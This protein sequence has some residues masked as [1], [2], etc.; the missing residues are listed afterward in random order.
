MYLAV[1]LGI[2][3]QRH[4]P[5]ANITRQHLVRVQ[6]HRHVDLLGLLR[7]GFVLGYCALSYIA[8]F[9][10]ESGLGAVELVVAE[11]LV[12]DSDESVE[13]RFEGGVACGESGN[14]DGVYTDFRC[15]DAHNYHHEEDDD[16]G[17]RYDPESYAC[18]A[19]GSLPASFFV[20]HG[21][22]S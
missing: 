12:L 4:I 9:V 16:N 20:P 14:A 11:V 1:Q 21:C 8:A 2:R 6:R 13:I 18:Q 19:P 5:G 15:L 17:L 3:R 7:L 10:A 22:D